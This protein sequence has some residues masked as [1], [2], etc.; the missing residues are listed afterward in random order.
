MVFLELHQEDWGSSLVV[1]GT[2]G[3]LSSCLRKVKSPFGLRGAPRDSSRITAGMNRASSRVEAG[4]SAILS[5]SDIHL[6]VSVEFEQ[7]RQ[8]SSYLQTLNSACLLSCE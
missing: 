8:D 1:T 4:T 3:T 2:S 7:G 6:E 5:I